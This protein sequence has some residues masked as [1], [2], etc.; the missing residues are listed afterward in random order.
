[1]QRKKI[2][3]N[4][5]KE[6][7]RYMGF[8]KMSNMYKLESQRGERKMWQKKIMERQQKKYWN[9]QWPRIFQNW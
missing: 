1:M 7:W 8:S 6:Y 4:T 3:E 2:M 9:K 5:E